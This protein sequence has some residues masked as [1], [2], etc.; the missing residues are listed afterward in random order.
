MKFMINKM[1]YWKDVPL[2]F[3][4]RQW[5]I[6]VTEF[7]SFLCPHPSGTNNC[8]TNNGGCAQLCLSYPGGR[9]C[10]CGRG[11][12]A[13]SATSCAPLPDCPAGEESCFDGSRCISSSRFCDGHVDCP[14]QSDEQDCEFGGEIENVFCVFPL[15][16]WP[17]CKNLKFWSLV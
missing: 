8:S 2:I 7:V 17:R 3:S 5:W 14:D 6:C 12:S 11:F 9:T 16:L 1:Y 13:V 4:W 10:K 15:L